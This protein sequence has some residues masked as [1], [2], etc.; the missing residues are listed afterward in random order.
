M[1]NVAVLLIVGQ[2]D[3]R[4]TKSDKYAAENADLEF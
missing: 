2:S 4:V 3:S 1:P